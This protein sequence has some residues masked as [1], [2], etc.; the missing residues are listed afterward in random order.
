[1]TLTEILLGGRILRQ[2][3]GRDVGWPG[4]RGCP[5]CHCRKH[6]PRERATAMWLRLK[7]RQCCEPGCVA[8]YPKDEKAKRHLYRC[9][10]HRAELKA[11]QKLAR[12]F[13]GSNAQNVAP[14]VV[15]RKRRVV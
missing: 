2:L 4:T 9:D 1:M 7:Y 14:V 12:S 11:R 15:T 3:F 5:I 8:N 10:L 13:D 6:L